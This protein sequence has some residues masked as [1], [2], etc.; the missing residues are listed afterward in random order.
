MKKN[1]TDFGCGT[2][3]GILKGAIE[4]TNEAFVT[5]D[6]DSRVI[7]F[8]RAAE[9]IF[10]YSRDEI[11]GRDLADILGPGCREGHQ[12]AVARYVKTGEAKLIGHE[13]QFNAMRKNGESFPA[14]ISFSVVE[15]NSDLFFTGIIRDMTETLALQEKVI[16][17][18]RLAALGQ[19][20]AEISHEIKNPLLL[21]GGF[22]RQLLKSDLNAKDRHKLKIIAEEVKRL[23]K[24]LAEMN[25]RAR[26]DRGLAGPPGR[27]PRRAARL[28][29]GLPRG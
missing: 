24:L 26:G 6:Q 27:G 19:A 7:I 29:G 5:I 11:I 20:V 10:G 13:T 18:E 22:A 8:N 9:Q 28:V 3:L 1:Y 15:I 17:G 23:E 21:I 4:N 16:A 2:A 25:G 12:M 14:A